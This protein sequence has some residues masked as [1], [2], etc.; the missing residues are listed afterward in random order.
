MNSRTTKQLRCQ[1]H[2]LPIIAAPISAW[3][4]LV[5]LRNHLKRILKRR[6]N[7]VMYVLSKTFNSKSR[8]QSADDVEK[9][10]TLTNLK[11]GDIVQIKSRNEIKNTLNRWNQLKGCTFMEE[12]WQYCG[13]QQQVFNRVERFLDERDYLMKKTRGIV[14]LKEVTCK[15][16]KDFGKCD[17]S[18][19]YFWREEW[20]EK[21][22]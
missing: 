21:A 13:T 18:C 22:K 5:S 16:T 9:I 15:G 17:R 20:L 6:M 12:M 10:V 3:G 11:P 14:I 8:L 2:S 19:F 7:F 1:L 4:M